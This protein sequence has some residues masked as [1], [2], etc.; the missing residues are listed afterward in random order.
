VYDK[1]DVPVISDVANYQY[2][3]PLRRLAE[4]FIA[5]HIAPNLQ[6]YEFIVTAKEKINY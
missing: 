6:I 2:A 4:E 1:N 3:W 5:T